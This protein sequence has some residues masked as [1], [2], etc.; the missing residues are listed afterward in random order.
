MKFGAFGFFDEVH[1]VR[2]D[3]YRV[4]HVELFYIHPVFELLAVVDSIFSSFEEVR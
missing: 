1:E 3:E 2:W 4:F